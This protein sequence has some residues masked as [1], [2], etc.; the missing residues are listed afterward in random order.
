[1]E[2]KCGGFAAS[3][4]DPR[5]HYCRKYFRQKAAEKSPPLSVYLQG[6]P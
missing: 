4:R 2:S 3:T 6:S 1:M 5:A